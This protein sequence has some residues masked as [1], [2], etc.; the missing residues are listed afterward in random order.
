MK[1]VHEAITAL[2]SVEGSFIS[3]KTIHVLSSRLVEVRDSF[4]NKASLS[5]VLNTLCA[6]C[7]PSLGQ[8]WLMN[9]PSFAIADDRS[10]ACRFLESTGSYTPKE[11]QM[12]AVYSAIDWAEKCIDAKQYRIYKGVRIISESDLV[13]QSCLL[14]HLRNDMEVRDPSGVPPRVLFQS[15]LSNVI[16]DYK[17]SDNEDMMRSIRTILQ[18]YDY[19]QLGVLLH[20][21]SNMWDDRPMIDGDVT[22]GDL[23]GH[24]GFV[25][26]VAKVIEFHLRDN[27]WMYTAPNGETVCR[28]SA[29]VSWYYT[30]AG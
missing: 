27:C 30:I 9:P 6:L 11:A 29:L 2:V 21:M 26:F 19:A 22:L 4:P 5:V 7:D 3:P 12:L 13:Y 18:G 17:R 14:G 10:T 23:T 28:Q 1:S 8:V 20:E 15:F 16:C 24:S 25:E